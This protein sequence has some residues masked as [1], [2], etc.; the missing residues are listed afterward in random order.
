MFP[1]EINVV[2]N[3]IAKT[4]FS[5]IKLQVSIFVNPSCKFDLAF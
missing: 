4:F 5:S 3:L 1:N 2:D